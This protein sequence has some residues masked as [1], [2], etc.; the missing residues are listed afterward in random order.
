M[1]VSHVQV[2]GQ[3]LG[4]MPKTWKVALGLGFKGVTWSTFKKS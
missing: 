3:V 4:Y 1:A 2:L